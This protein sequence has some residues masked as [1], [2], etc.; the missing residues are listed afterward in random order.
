MKIRI[1]NNCY[2]RSLDQCRKIVIVELKFD[3]GEKVSTLFYKSTGINS[4][5]PGK[6]F[7]IIGIANEV[8]EKS[9]IN[10]VVK[11]IYKGGINDSIKNHS[12]GWFI[13]YIGDENNPNHVYRM[14]PNLKMGHLL[15]NISIF[16]R[17]TEDKLGENLFEDQFQLSNYL[18]NNLKNSGDFSELFWVVCNKSSKVLSF[19]ESKADYPFKF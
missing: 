10:D 1:V 8:F 18:I 17:N 3:N 14:S 12:E 7:P 6:W 9:F 16:L 19:Y 13:K 5:K 2:C 4:K 11:L 15:E